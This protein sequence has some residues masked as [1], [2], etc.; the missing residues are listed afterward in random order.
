M[1]DEQIVK[2]LESCIKGL[3]NG[4]CVDCPLKG[5]SICI[6]DPFASDRLA[7]D[8]IKRQQAEI[9]GLKAELKK[10]RDEE[11]EEDYK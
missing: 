6:N 2:I 4:E 11:S 5:A 8:L 3:V 9:K 10:I 7:L 1:T